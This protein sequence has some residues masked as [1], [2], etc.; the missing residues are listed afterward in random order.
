MVSVSPCNPSPQ[1]M[2]GAPRDVGW[3][4][5]G[6][7]F[8][9]GGGPGEGCGAGPGQAPAIQSLCSLFSV[10]CSADPGRILAPS[11]LQGE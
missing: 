4:F 11:K 2:V 1:A 9:R 5:A 10:T 3:A 6:R 7:T 8:P